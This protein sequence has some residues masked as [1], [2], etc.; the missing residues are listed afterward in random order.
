MNYP[1]GSIPKKLIGPVFIPFGENSSKS[2]PNN[3]FILSEQV[4]AIL[5]LGQTIPEDT[6]FGA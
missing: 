3:I 6:L 4:I 2:Y 5:F 1:V